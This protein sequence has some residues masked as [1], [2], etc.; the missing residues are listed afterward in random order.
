MN[1]NMQ[2][3]RGKSD[4]NKKNN[5]AIFDEVSRAFIQNIYLGKIYLR[6]FFS[7]TTTCP[8]VPS[9]LLYS[10][11]LVTLFFFDITQ[12]FSS[13]YWRLTCMKRKCYYKAK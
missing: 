5:E 12:M 6:S 11:L 9:S 3:G 1:K 7:A 2:K 13:L 10:Y 8:N 4:D